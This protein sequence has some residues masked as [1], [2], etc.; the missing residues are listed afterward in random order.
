MRT[1]I[2]RRQ[3]YIP[4]RRPI[5]ADRFDGLI[6]ELIQNVMQTDLAEVRGIRGELEES[7]EHNFHFESWPDGRMA[8]STMAKNPEVAKWHT[9]LKGDIEFTDNASNFFRACAYRIRA[10]NS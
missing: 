8:V 3:P 10:R 5:G 2:G 1:R 4:A 7:E 9:K 6:P